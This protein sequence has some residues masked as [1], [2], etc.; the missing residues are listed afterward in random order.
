MKEAFWD[1]VLTEENGKVTLSLNKAL[2]IKVGEAVL[3]ME[4]SGAIRLKGTKVV[5]E[6]MDVRVCGQANAEL[7]A[8]GVVTVKGAILKLK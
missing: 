8:C 2:T 1:S 3:T 6:G 5:V 7:S 4:P